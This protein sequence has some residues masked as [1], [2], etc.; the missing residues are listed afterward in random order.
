MM[1]D[2]FLW[3]ERVA[4]LDLGPPPLPLESVFPSCECNCDQ[5]S[6][7]MHLTQGLDHRP[8]IYLTG[9]APAMA[10]TSSSSS[11]ALL[12]ALD[13]A[14]HPSTR[15]RAAA[16]GRRLRSSDQ[17]S[18]LPRCLEK[19]KSH[20]VEYQ[21]RSCLKPRVPRPPSC[22]LVPSSCELM[23]LHVSRHSTHL[24]SLESSVIP[25]ID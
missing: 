1:L 23:T 13:K 6:R 14:S 4:W 18:A 19:I 11:T 16:F 2:Q 22:P 7:R 17:E 15:L 21:R 5:R 20:Y 25:G 3:A 9:E 10:P 24:V 12:E 8:F